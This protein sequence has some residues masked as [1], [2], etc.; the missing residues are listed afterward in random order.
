MKSSN[1]LYKIIFGLYFASILLLLF[2]INISPDLYSELYLLGGTCRYSSVGVEG[3]F[4]LSFI[5]MLIAANFAVLAVLGVVYSAR[6][7][8]YVLIALVMNILFIGLNSKLTQFHAFRGYK[9]EPTTDMFDAISRQCYVYVG[10][11]Y[12]VLLLIILLGVYFIWFG[13]EPQ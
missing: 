12:L 1:F 2:S 4:K 6:K 5:F 3:G 9:I 7:T 11:H 13:R 8:N 10:P